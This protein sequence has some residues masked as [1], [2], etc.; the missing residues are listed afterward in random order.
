[1]ILESRDK[2][3]GKMS[4]STMIHSRQSEENVRVCVER[5]EKRKIRE[6]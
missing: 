2:A 3:E 5:K 4:N 6:R 1:M